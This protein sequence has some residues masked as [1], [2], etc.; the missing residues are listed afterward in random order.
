MSQTEQGKLDLD[1]LPDFLDGNNE[2]P[3]AAERSDLASM[4]QRLTSPDLAAAL[5]AV[6][7]M[8]KGGHAELQPELTDFFYNQAPH[9]VH[10][11]IE[12]VL[13]CLAKVGD[14]RCVRGME[15]VLHE[16]WQVLNEH[17]AWRGRHIVQ[18]IRRG[19][20]K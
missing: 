4:R 12:K 19:G 6:D 9:L 1:D 3:P 5:A 18:S 16:R 14:G 11:E 7:E 10:E 20:R 13:D 15:R 8:A 2:H 17:Q